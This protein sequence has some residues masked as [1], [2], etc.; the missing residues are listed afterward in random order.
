MTN[1]NSY[2]SIQNHG[3][4]KGLYANTQ[5]YDYSSGKTLAGA[6]EGVDADLAAWVNA[7]RELHAEIENGFSRLSPS[8]QARFMEWWDWAAPQV[9]GVSSD[10]GSFDMTVDDG[11]RMGGDVPAEM[12]PFGGM[13]GTMG[14]W[15]YTEEKF[16]GG[17]IGNGT[18][19]I[20]STDVLLQV[21]PLSAKVTIE[22]TTDT[23]F[24]PPEDVRKITVTDAAT[25]T[26]AVYFVHDE[27]AEIE[28]QT[29]KQEQITD[30][31]AE[32]YHYNKFVPGSLDAKATNE[33][34]VAGVEENGQL[35]YEGRVGETIAFNSTGG[36]DQEHVVWG[37]ADITVG[38]RDRVA[39]Y[40]SEIADSANEGETI[41]AT[42]IV[43]NHP[44]GT[45]D[46]YFVPQGMDFTTNINAIESRITWG[47]DGLAAELGEAV[48]INA[49]GEAQEEEVEAQG[50]QPTRKEDNGE[51]TFD[52][53]SFEIYSRNDGRTSRVFA[54]SE[55][56]F[57]AT[58]NTEYWKVTKDGDGNYVVT[59]FDN[60]DHTGEA[61]ETFLVD[62]M[63]D[64]V[65]FDVEASHLDVTALGEDDEAVHTVGPDGQ[66]DAA[67]TGDWVAE[68]VLIENMNSD[69]S[70]RS[71]ADAV[72]E[73][74]R[75][76]DWA[77]V[78]ALMAGMNGEGGN[79]IM[80]RFLSG[81]YNAV[82]QD[83]AAFQKALDLIPEEVRTRMGDI[84]YATWVERSEKADGDVW[85]SHETYEI[86][87]NSTYD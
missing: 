74:V 32:H 40:A 69:I 29:A 64:K 6:A 18:Y 83:D 20:W 10:W 73:A 77:G 54:R 37:N 7:N 87:Y 75:S 35:V 78:N 60:A 50:D 42:K 25:G 57:H 9:D 36:S 79:D 44:D 17:F 66:A 2:S 47:S 24:Q 85:N 30:Y 45:S 5:D 39:V 59:V 84:A 76:G 23:R 72:D 21:A 49:G 12:I 52:G 3:A 22:N 34:S 4:A 82:N 46:T 70:A 68:G 38:T 65:N 19:D 56:T 11:T 67:G 62:A 13:P 61:K 28:I 48:T 58:S 80:R 71:F 43:V 26:E 51:Y 31:S 27:T 14:N 55:V 15:T 41:P 86:L 33:A 53:S 63:A 16:R 8:D 81:L 1:L